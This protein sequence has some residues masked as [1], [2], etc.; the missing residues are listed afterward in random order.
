MYNHALRACRVADQAAKS[1]K[2]EWESVSE[3]FSAELAKCRNGNYEFSTLSASYIANL[4]YM[5]WEWLTANVAHIFPAQEYPDN[6]KVAVGGLAYAGGVSR[7]LYQLLAGHKVFA[8]ALAAKLEDKNSRERVIEWV[9]LAYLWGDEQLQSPIIKTIFASGIEDIETL[10]ELFWQVRQD[11]LT[12]DQ[13]SRVLS[14]W[15][16]CLSWITEYGEKP[17]RLMA[18]LSR[19]SPYIR[20]LDERGSVLL[21]AVMPFVHTDYGTDQ[22]VEELTSFLETNV[23][24]VAALL[25]KMLEA[26]A[27]TYDLD[28][29]LKTLIEMLAQRGLRAEA[30]RCAEKVRRTLPGMLDLYKK[31]VASG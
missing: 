3:V 31:L 24:G 17:D 1:H 7:T 30:I 26:S 28:D 18:R 13:V 19:L 12:Q 6:F 10:A 23:A 21:M 11:E 22:M 27:P 16:R 8:D 20:T 5:S 4:D 14:F 29:K 2:A 9:G 15:E 25:E